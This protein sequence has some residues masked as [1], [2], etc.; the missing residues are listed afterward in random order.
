MI[1]QAHRYAQTSSLHIQAFNPNPSARHHIR[2]LPSANSLPTSECLIKIDFGEP[3]LQELSYLITKLT[4]CL[5]LRLSCLARRCQTG[6]RWKKKT[7]KYSNDYKRYWLLSLTTWQLLSLRL[8]WGLEIKKRYSY[9]FK[10]GLYDR[11]LN[12]FDNKFFES[13]FGHVYNRF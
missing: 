10:S 4:F 5:P 2:T 6:K 8:I 1:I 11:L 7:R 12:E 9:L 3:T 13:T